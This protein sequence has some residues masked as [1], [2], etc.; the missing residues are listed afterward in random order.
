MLD[1]WLKLRL[2]MILMC[3]VKKKGFVECMKVKKKNVLQKIRKEKKKKKYISQPPRRIELL[4]PG[5]RDQCSA[6][7]L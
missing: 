5:L 1:Q 7:E 4:T 2:V 3:S 6:A